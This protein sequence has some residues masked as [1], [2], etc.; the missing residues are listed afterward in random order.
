MGGGCPRTEHHRG[1]H[2]LCPL[3]G[4]FLSLS[5]SVPTQRG[6]YLGVGG[7]TVPFTSDLNLQ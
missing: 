5:L 1:L 2:W 7:S 6:Q 3:R 4:P